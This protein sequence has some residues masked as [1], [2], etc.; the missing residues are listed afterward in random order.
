MFEDTEAAQDA[1]DTLQDFEL[2]G[3]PMKLDFAKTR[4]DKTVEREDGPEALAQ[5]VE[6]RKAEKSE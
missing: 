2:F 3:K 4:S 5:H 6:A 1:V